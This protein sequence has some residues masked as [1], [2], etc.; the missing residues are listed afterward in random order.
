VHRSTLINTD[1]IRK[2]SLSS[3]RWLLKMSN[4]FEAVVSKRWRRPSASS[5]AGSR[6]QAFS[7]R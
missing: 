4:G 3:R 5:L 1:H 7:G 6:L 2:I